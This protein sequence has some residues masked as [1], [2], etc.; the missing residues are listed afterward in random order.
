MQRRGP[1]EL[2]HLDLTGGTCGGSKLYSHSSCGLA[3][4]ERKWRR[5]S[6]AIGVGGRTRARG[7]RTCR[8]DGET[9]RALSCYSRLQGTTRVQHG[10]HAVRVASEPQVSALDPADCKGSALVL[11]KA[12]MT[13]RVWLS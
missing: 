7:A 5:E 12:R 3:A 6:G 10:T 9:V 4:Q 2:A 8:V 1:H 13:I 11:L